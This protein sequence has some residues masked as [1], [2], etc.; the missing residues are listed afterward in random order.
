MSDVQY[1]VAKTV[2]EAASL[3]LAAKG[4][5]RILAG[6]TDLLVQMKSGMVAPGVIIDVKKIPEMTTITET[7]GSFRIGA[8]TPAAV[9]GEHKKLKKTWPGV[10]EAINLIGST[11]GHGRASARGHLCH[12]P[13][14]ARSVPAPVADRAGVDIPGTN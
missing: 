5:G 10:V 12:A 3:M 11:Q 4:K 7:K 13:P 6:G 2:R 8:A 1:K 9:V 14:A